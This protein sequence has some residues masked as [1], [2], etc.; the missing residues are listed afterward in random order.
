MN[1]Q[2]SPPSSGSPPPFPGAGDRYRSRTGDGWQ[3]GRGGPQQGGA[4]DSGATGFK[5]PNPFRLYRNVKEGK[6]AGICAGIAEYANIE[7]WLVR[8]GVIAGFFFFPPIFIIGY[9][10]LWVSLRPKPNDLFENTEEEGF[11]RSVATRPDQTVA[12]LKGKFRELD[13]SIGGMEGFVA[14]REFDLHRQFRDLEKK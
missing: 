12:A 3:T 7:T 5:S 10:A 14:S 13:R 11:W 2:D 4:P 1:G 9:L 8:V 6:V